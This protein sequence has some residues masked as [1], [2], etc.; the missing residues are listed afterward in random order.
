MIEVINEGSSQSIV[1]SDTLKGSL[2]NKCNPG[3]PLAYLPHLLERYY[4][5]PV[6]LRRIGRGPVKIYAH[7]YLQAP[8]E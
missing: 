4:L 2:D 3:N 1:F 7:N 5:A 8:A 6:L